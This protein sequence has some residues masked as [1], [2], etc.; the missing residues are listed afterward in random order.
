MTAALEVCVCGYEAL[1]VAGPRHVYFNATAAC[2]A[3]YGEVLGR[4]FTTPALLPIHH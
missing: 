1:A 2:W 3:A 4:G